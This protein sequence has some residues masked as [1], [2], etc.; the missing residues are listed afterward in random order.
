M[1]L[2]KDGQPVC[3]KQFG[4]FKLLLLTSLSL[5]LNASSFED[6]KNAQSESYSNF[7]EKQD[8]AFSDNLKKQFQNFRK[9]K[10]EKLYEKPKPKKIKT[11]KKAPKIKKEGPIVKVVVPKKIK[12]VEPKP[13]VIKV[14]KK[15]L[16]PEVKKEDIH[17]HEPIVK[18]IKKEIEKVVVKN[19]NTFKFFGTDVQFSKTIKFND[20][21]Y[22]PKN[23]KGVVNF[24]DK[25]SAKNYSNHIAE[26]KQNIKNLNL[27]DWG[28]YLLVKKGS[29][30]YFKDKDSKNLY[31]WF[32]LNHL[33]YNVK[34][35][36]N[37][38]KPILLSY[39]KNTV[40]STAN[41]RFGSKKF[42]ALDFYA[43]GSL[44]SVKSYPKDYANATKDMD[45][46]LKSL[47]R[48]A[49]VKKTKKLSFKHLGKTYRYSYD[50][51][52]NLLDFL[53]TYPQAHYE[54]FFNAPLDEIT[55]TS[56][57]KSIKPM[58]DK[59]QASVALNFVLNMVQKSFD[60][61]TDDEQFGREKVMFPQETLYFRSSDCEDRATLYSYLV[62]V[63]FGVKA[64]GI[65]YPNHMATAILAPIN[66]DSVDYKSTR[67][68][69]ADPTYINASVGM[70]MP[71]FK[72]LHP[73][74]FIKV[75][76]K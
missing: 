40:Y 8:K 17:K 14:D 51:N 56:L 45:L 57:I 5:S 7:V 10:G 52:Q 60:Y 58:I 1:Q 64:F 41:Y 15:L 24:F 75:S 4:L 38:S 18:P 47:P 25:I 3:Y 53:A 54:A 13:I 39:S 12:F 32:V 68:V 59:K 27:N 37:N 50:Y 9:Y 16:E 28:V 66:G 71:Q 46:S 6:Y 73:K 69:V 23:Q 63:L 19:V 35:A 26:Y 33:G 36:L 42:Y 34:L 30:F 55:K 65:T 76:Q 43:K 74:K 2:I 48:L 11:V 70:A 20:L 72:K 21:N 31:R 49:L 22:Y 29:E 44:G 67:Y 62:E 61:K